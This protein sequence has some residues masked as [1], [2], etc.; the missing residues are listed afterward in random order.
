ML[1]WY[2][3]PYYLYIFVVVVVLIIEDMRRHRQRTRSQG[4]FYGYVRGDSSDAGQALETR[5]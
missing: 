5:M 2:C 4:V 3:H 1:P